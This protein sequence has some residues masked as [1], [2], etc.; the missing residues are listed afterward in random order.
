MIAALKR[1]KR[2]GYR[3]IYL[4]ETM[5]TRSTVPKSEYCLPEQNM[6]VTLAWINEPT[7]AVLSGISREK[8]QELFM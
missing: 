8:G 1:A 5:F 6:T 3:I 4:D 7:M 2:D